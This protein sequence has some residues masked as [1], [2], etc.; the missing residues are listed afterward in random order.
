MK[1]TSAG[2]R[3]VR[4]PLFH[5][6]FCFAVSKPGVVEEIRQSAEAE[7]TTQD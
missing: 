2:V 7:R 1:S 4:T 6:R 3:D 5:L